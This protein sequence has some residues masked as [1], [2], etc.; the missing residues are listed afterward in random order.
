MADFLSIKPSYAD[1]EVENGEI[2]LDNDNTKRIVPCVDL[3]G[4]LI[5]MTGHAVGILHEWLTQSDGQLAADT[6]DGKT[7]TFPRYVQ[8]V[9]K[10]KAG[11]AF[12][13]ELIKQIKATREGTG[14]AI[15]VKIIGYDTQD[16]KTVSGG[17]QA[18]LQVD[19]KTIPNSDSSSV[20]TVQLKNAV[21][22]AP[23]AEAVSPLKGTFEEFR[24]S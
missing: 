21:D 3:N 16:Y 23:K 8:V 20:I 22:D 5:M 24:L 7:L 19:S 13:E 9:A 1:Q 17:V 12:K 11:K 18:T 6:G 10:G 2:G 15:A 4:K 14:K